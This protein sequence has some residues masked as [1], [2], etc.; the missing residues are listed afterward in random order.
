MINVASTFQKC[1]LFLP[2]LNIYGMS[3][4]FEQ[5]SAEHLAMKEVKEVLCFASL[6]NC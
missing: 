4:P 2:S 1:C 3:D 6:H 5:E